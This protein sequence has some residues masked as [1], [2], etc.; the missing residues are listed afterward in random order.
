M[1]GGGGAGCTAE[2]S[3][4]M[5]QIAGVGLGCGRNMRCKVG[6]QWETLQ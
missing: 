6:P 4:R 2:G 5:A 1:C 3:V